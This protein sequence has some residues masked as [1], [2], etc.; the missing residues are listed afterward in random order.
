MPAVSTT[1]VRSVKSGDPF[2]PLGLLN[3][4]NGGN[5]DRVGLL[6]T[7]LGRD[8]L[9]GVPPAGS[10]SEMMRS[11]LCQCLGPLSVGPLSL[12]FPFLCP[13]RQS[14][15]SRESRPVKVV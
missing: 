9:R 11:R 13:S 1:L 3:R 15:W 10:R 2:P 7:W 5:R 4:G 12:S 14:C 8:Q 6:L